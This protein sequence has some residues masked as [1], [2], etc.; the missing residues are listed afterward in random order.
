ME[1]L[2]KSL[3]T[4]CGRTIEKSRS[5]TNER[6]AIWEDHESDVRYVQQ[7]RHLRGLSHRGLLRDTRRTAMYSSGR[8]RVSAR[9][10]ISLA[11]EARQHVE[12][13][14]CNLDGS[15]QGAIAAQSRSQARPILSGHW[16]HPLADNVL[17]DPPSKGE[18][19]RR[20][21]SP[22]IHFQNSRV[23]CRRR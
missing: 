7:D 20:E 22:L 11:F 1:N 15:L 8:V 5:T 13:R 4:I 3:S 12:A 17:R 14:P 16:P 6:L 19:L 21:Q 10:T 9:L 2:R 23:E 18:I